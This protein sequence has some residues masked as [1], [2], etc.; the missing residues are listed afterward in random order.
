MFASR[1][2]RRLTKAVKPVP[3]GFQGVTPYLVV[4][5][6]DKL[7]DF[8]KQAFRAEETVRMPT[9]EGKVGHAEVRIGGSVGMGATPPRP[10]SGP[11]R[12]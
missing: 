8:L 6:A 3:Q 11:C 2:E 7:I 1:L 5:G 12:A 9:P 4:E 10:S